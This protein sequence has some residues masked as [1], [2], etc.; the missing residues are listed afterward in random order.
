MKPLLPMYFS[1]MQTWFHVVY[2]LGE[3]GSFVDFATFR[4][5][6]IVYPMLYNKELIRTLHYVQ[7]CMNIG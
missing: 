6:K 5:A 7:C 2:R 4:I 3:V 1:I